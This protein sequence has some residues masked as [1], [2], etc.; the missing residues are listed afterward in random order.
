M[1]GLVSFFL[2]KRVFTQGR[3]IS[4]WSVS[5][6]LFTQMTSNINSSK[7]RF[8]TVLCTEKFVCIT[9][10]EKE[11][12]TIGEGHCVARVI[13]IGQKDAILLET[14]PSSAPDWDFSDFL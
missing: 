8:V 4:S 7:G 10:F 5:D 6:S 1:F 11:N 12:Y 13:W 2:L 14:H 3:L 9:F